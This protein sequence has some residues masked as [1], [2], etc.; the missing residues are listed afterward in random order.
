MTQTTKTVFSDLAK[1]VRSQDHDHLS[2]AIEG[3]IRFFGPA[4]S[5][6]PQELRAVLDTD[7]EDPQNL[8]N[9]L[10]DLLQDTEGFDGNRFSLLTV[11]EGARF[12]YPKTPRRSWV[13]LA[14]AIR[15]MNGGEA[16]YPS[17]MEALL[18]GQRVHRAIDE[19]PMPEEDRLNV[20]EV[21]HDA[22]R[23]E[24][25]REGVASMVA[26]IL[27][28]REKFDVERFVYHASSDSVADDD[29]EAGKWSYN[30]THRAEAQKTTI[31]AS[32]GETI[33]L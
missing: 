15:Q 21:F 29:S 5:A 33:E 20:R 24:K 6:D 11:G 18:A 23:A 9:T 22:V 14:E 31:E 16:P 32:S 7:L 19:L 13:D 4:L 1:A 8:S 30:R 12:K 17:V 26:A 27:T 25:D 10:I 28:G 3:V 2:E